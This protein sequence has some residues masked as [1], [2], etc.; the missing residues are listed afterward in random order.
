MKRDEIFRTVCAAGG[1]CLAAVWAVAGTRAGEAVVLHYAGAIGPVAVRY[2]D[3][4]IG[5]AERRGAAVVVLELDTPGG[6]GNSMRQIIQQ[7]MNARIPVVVYVAPRGARAASAGCLIV[8]AADV[9]AMAPGTTIGAAHPLGPGG[10]PV[11]EKILNDAAAYARVLAAAHHR[12]QTWAEQAVRQSVSATADQ[13][14]AGGVVDVMAADL[15]DLLRQLEGRRVPAF[16]GG[17]ALALAPPQI[18]SVDMDWREQFLDGLARPD[19]AYLLVVLGLLGVIVEAFAPHGLLT[20]SLGA[21][22]LLAGLVGLALVPVD[23]IG[24][25]LLAVGILLLVLELKISLHGVLALVG[26]G[27]FVLGS[28][29]LVPRVPGYRL[30]TWLVALLALAWVG[31]TGVVLRQVMLARRKPVLTGIERMIGAEGVAKTSLAPRGVVLVGS[32][33]WAAEAESESVGAGERVRVVEVQG[34][35][36]RVRRVS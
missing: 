20:G 18:V 3:R 21:L 7:E 1:L 4:G 6:L 34:L 32:E 15:N 36:L 35:T 11:S 26:A 30:S 16:K 10:G 31:V 13:A 19:L 24:L 25:A 22:A 27:L 9:A 17:Q 14:L 23:A 29:L 8:M 2:I 5:D 28:L 33:D 12:N